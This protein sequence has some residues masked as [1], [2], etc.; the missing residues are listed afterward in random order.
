[1]IIKEKV[2][3]VLEEIFKEDNISHIFPEDGTLDDKLQMLISESLIA[4]Q[5]T[6]SL[7]DEFEI[8]FEDDEVDY[9]FFSSIDSIVETV[10]KHIK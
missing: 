9:D 7:E 6:C 8:E 2:I 3:N 5:I 10:Q 4:L 1:M